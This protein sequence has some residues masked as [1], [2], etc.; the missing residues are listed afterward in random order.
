MN[1]TDTLVARP[2]LQIQA[3]DDGVWLHF[4]TADGNCVGLNLPV[5][6]FFN[7]DTF[8]S[9]TIVQW[10]KEYADQQ[11]GRAPHLDGQTFSPYHRGYFAGLRAA[12]KEVRTHWNDQCTAVSQFGQA[13]RSARILEDMA[14]MG[15]ENGVC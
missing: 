7:G 10:C 3:A 11:A 14:K 4:K 2:E 9:R 5:A 8:T 13:G 1:V 12:A 15:E 6:R